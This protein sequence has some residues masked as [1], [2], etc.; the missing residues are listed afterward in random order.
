[1]YGAVR[2]K[3][4]NE[5]VSPFHLCW[6]PSILFFLVFS[7]IDRQRFLYLFE[8]LLTFISLTSDDKRV[9]K[10]RSEKFVLYILFE[11]Y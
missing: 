6:C 3:M 11:I 8:Q 7:T 9:E 4:A 2:D 1:M 10:H 5:I